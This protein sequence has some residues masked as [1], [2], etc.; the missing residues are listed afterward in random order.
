MKAFISLF[1]F[2]FFI[3]CIP[4]LF[5]ASSLRITSAPS[6]ARILLNG[7][8][9][10]K[11]TPTTLKN[12]EEGKKYKVKLKKDGYKDFETEVKGIAG[13][14]H[15][16]AD[17]KKNPKAKD[18]SKESSKSASKDK[19]DAA[20]GSAVERAFGYNKIYKE[21]TY[22][23]L[24]V[25]TTPSGAAVYIDDKRQVG[26]TP[27]QYKLPIGKVKVS[28]VIKGK[29]VREFPVVSIAA[30]QVTKLAPIDF[31][32]EVGRPNTEPLLKGD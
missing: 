15:V 27:N 8:E 10:K 29:A 7:E 13:V 17:L 3:I 31:R 32:D 23:W 2:L 1:S 18:S 26:P 5:A 28:V 12:V 25:S 9:Q 14:I 19:T 16:H 22:G 20:S 21:G 4:T 6:K 11:P 30:G 24:E